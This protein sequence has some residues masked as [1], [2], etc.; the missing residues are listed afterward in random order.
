MAKKVQKRYLFPSDYMADPSVHVFDGKLYIYPSHDWESA[1]PDDDFGSEYDMKDYHVLSLEGNDP[2]TSPVKDN[3]VALDIKDVPWAR[4]QL[5]DNEVVK[6]RDGKYY[7]YFPAKDKTDI[8][9]CG[10]AISDSPTGPFK[11]MPDPIRGSYSIDYAILHD[12]ADDEY[13]MYFGGIW[14]G[15]LQRYEDNLAKDNGTSYPADGQPAV[16]GRV[17]KLAKDML[18]FAEEPK[19]VVLI[20][21]NGEPIKVEDNERRF[22]EASWMHKYKGKYYFSYSTGDTHKL[23]Y[24]IGD[25]PYGPFT[26]KGVILTPVYGWTTHHSIVE[27]NGKW[28]LF[29]HDSGISKGINRLR[30]LKVCELTYREDGTIETIEGLDQ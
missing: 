15:Q 21:E 14:G 22:F 17:V 9:R 13:Y 23:C 30:S 29:H 20:D 8:F 2:M 6:G 26:Y 4:R 25:N 28:W 11:A 16:P 18:Q 7:M 24:A 3:G 27:F 19:P 12:D 1:A 10:V 5:W